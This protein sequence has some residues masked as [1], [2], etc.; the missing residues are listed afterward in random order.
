[1]IAD[2]EDLAVALAI[3]LLEPL[4]GPV[5]VKALQRLPGGASRSTWSCDAI[6]TDGRPPVPLVFQQDRPG[7]WRIGPGMALEAGLLRAARRA[8]VPV[9]DVVVADGDA[10]TRTARVDLGPPWMVMGRIDGETVARRIFRAHDSARA[11]APIVAQC[12][13]ALAGIHRIAPSDAP[14]L[15]TPDRLEQQ[16]SILDEL[17]EPH[18]AFELGLRWLSAHRPPT[19]PPRVIHGDFRTGN[20]IVGADGLRAVLDWELAHLGDPLEDL[21]W[22][23]VRAWRFG[24]GLA[25]GGFGSREQLVAAYEDAGGQRVDLE[26]L[27]WWEVMG[28]LTWGVICMMQAATHRSGLSRSVELAAIGRRVCETEHDLLSLLP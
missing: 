17:G 12:G 21:G 5:T 26:A 8:G 23:C 15:A 11:R 1:M 2:P 13:A 7:G 3:A 14:G 19:S 6:P 20:L 10:S 4:G 24:S 18:P 9:A 28:T 25:A 16:R 22:F 27:R